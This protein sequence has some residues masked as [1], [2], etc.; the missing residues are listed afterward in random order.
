MPWSQFLY[1]MRSASFGMEK[2]QGSAWQFTPHDDSDSD[3]DIDSG[4]GAGKRSI[5]FHE[6]HP[7]REGASRFWSL[8]H[9]GPYSTRP[10]AGS[11]EPFR[12]MNAKVD[13]GVGR[14]PLTEEGKGPLMRSENRIDN[15]SNTLDS[16]AMHARRTQASL[17][18]PTSAMAAP[19]AMASKTDERHGKNTV[20]RN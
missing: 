10:N 14:C 8:Q 20:R 9:P 18:S 1:A 6:P 19:A 15:E 4:V 2:L 7:T 12:P 5:L 17:P 13:R 11:G 3:S 16:A